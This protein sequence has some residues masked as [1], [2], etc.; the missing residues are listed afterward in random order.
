[1]I[2]FSRRARLLISAG[3]TAITIGCAAVGPNYKSPATTVSPSW[4]SK[5]EGAGISRTGAD[6]AGWWTVLKDPQLDSL[7]S[8]AVAGNLDL[9]KARSRIR[10]A[11]A[12]R[13]V[14]RS[15]LFP[16][17]DFSGSASRSRTSEA[18]GTGN[19][20]ELYNAGFDAVWEVDIFGGVRRSV[21]ASEADL[22]ASREDWRDTLVTLLSETALNYIEVRTYQTR[23][24]VAESSLKAQAETYQLTQWRCDA[25]LSDRLAVEQAR[26]NLES[27]RSQ[28]PSLN[29]GREEAMNRLA[30]LTGVQPGALHK[31][32]EKISSIPAP[33]ASA[34]IGIPADMLRRRPDV[35]RAERQFAAQTSR[36]GVATADLYPKL[37]LS[38][39]IGLEALSVGNLF[40]VA[41]GFWS[42]VA[43]ATAPVFHAG[44]LRQKVEIQSALQEQA[45]LQYEQSVL[46]ALEEVENAIISYAQ[47]QARRDAL[48]E[49]VNA[50]QQAVAFS[51]AK[52]Q[53]GLSDFSAVLDAQRSLFS[54][55]D[56]LV[57]SE[58]TVTSNLVR[59]YK[60][61]GGGWESL[62]PDAGTAKPD[63]NKQ[64]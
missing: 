46:N 14:A 2:N 18:T 59:L 42:I 22:D 26:Y 51:E 48:R 33:P 27:T 43:G 63:G 15:S 56:Q 30:V 60:A 36:V 11:R 13:I 20:G 40:S 10:Q 19:T 17:L 41:N 47:E 28:I 23:I 21:E 50:A 7:V 35:R 5:T 6:L 58:G 3:L 61:L 24:T 37:T 12:Q 4:N 57:Q 31:E 39:S 62:N 16:S 44:A 8:R 29:T 9:K 25:G 64:S 49:S 38:G 1:M 34:A 52:Y 32:L 45:L 53:A 54:F 55:N